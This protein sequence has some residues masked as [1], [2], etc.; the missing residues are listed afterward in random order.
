MPVMLAVV[1]I[2]L[3]ARMPGRA[4]AIAIAFNGIA[5]QAAS[6]RAADHTNRTAVGNG[7]AD[8]AATNRTDNCTGVVI[9]SAATIRLSRQRTG[10]ERQD[11]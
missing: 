11:R 5:G 8:Q 4:A 9:A 7:V 3:M 10:A 2:D 6:D 1:V